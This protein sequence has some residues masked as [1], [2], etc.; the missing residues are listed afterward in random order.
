MSQIWEIFLVQRFYIRYFVGRAICLALI[1][2]SMA[3]DHTLYLDGVRESVNLDVSEA[4]ASLLLMA[5]A[6]DHYGEMLREWLDER[7]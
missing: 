1:K 4:A 7:E 6:V 5:E 3:E 2:F